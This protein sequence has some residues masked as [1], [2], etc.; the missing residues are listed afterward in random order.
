V[1]SMILAHAPVIVPAVAGI[2]LPF[3]RS[4]WAPLVLLHG[5]LAVRVVGAVV[6]A[7]PVKMWGGVGN[8]A[9]LAL[10]IALAAA[11]GASAARE[12][13]AGSPTLCTSPPLGSPAPPE[14][15]LRWPGRRSAAPAC[16]SSWWP[17]SEPAP[18][19]WRSPVQ[20]ER[21]S[22]CR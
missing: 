3:R 14:P 21:P 1:L 12:A 20:G 7:A 10:F 13:R 17:W 6:G 16:G 15:L 4:W 9:A 11:S 19:G 22:S 8:V 18:R 5:T 2:Q